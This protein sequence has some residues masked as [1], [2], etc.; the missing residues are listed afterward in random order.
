[1]TYKRAFLCWYP[2]FLI[3]ALGLFLEMAVIRWLAAEV[4]LFSYFKNLPLMAAFL[5]LGIGF[6]LVGRARDYRPTFAL[7]IGLFVP[8]VLVVGRLM[9]PR[10]LAYPGWGDE[11]LWF[12]GDFAYWLALALFLG[13]VITFFLLTMFLFI[14]LGQAT[15][16]EMAQHKPVP[17]Y[18]V[19]LVGSLAGIWA[20]TLLSYWHTPPA[21]WFGLA[22]FG[23]GIYLATKRALSRPAVIIFV[24][25]FIALL[26]FGQGTIWSP[27]HRL[28]FGE[29]YLERESNGEPVK[30]GYTLTVQ[31]VFYQAATDL[32]EDF[33][34][35]LQGDVRGM[36]EAAFSYNL[37]YR[38]GAASP[39]VLVV[40]A[41]MG[42]DVAAALRQDAAHVDA[43]E[44][45]PAILELGHELH[46][47]APYDDARVTVI[48]DDARSFL[49]KSSDSYDIIAFGLLDS[50]TL[51]S[52]LSSVR[53]DS[54]VYT[55]ESFEQVREHLTDNGLVAVTFAVG[56]PWIEERLGQMLVEVF[57]TDRVFVYHGS[58]GTTF[59]TGSIA[60]DRLAEV[61]LSV[62][63]P[64]P[65]AEELPLATDDWP[66]LY[67]RVRKVPTAYW[68]ALLAIG[69]VCVA[70]VARS[71]P[72]ALRPKWHFFLLGAAFLLIEFKIITELALLFGTTWLVN[73]LAVSGVLLMA[74]AANLV[75]LWRKRLNLRIAY[76][77]LFVSLGANYFFPLSLLSGFSPAIR[78]VM[79]LALLSLPLF[80]AGLIFGESL[81]RAKETARPLASN[82]IGSVAGGV[83]FYGSLI[84]G[85]KS[86]ILIA[87][88]IYAGSLL[89]LVMR[90]K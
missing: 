73:V 33:L 47:E 44:I 39:Q 84:W 70:V 51:L 90:K 77:L 5:G 29:L 60:P 24:A 16:K 25:V 56:A 83:L 10:L 88:V 42:N 22:L 50:Q 2:L 61:G 26:L 87:A 31:Q 85:I 37:P 6:A 23:V 38:L 82:L 67:L 3:S 59:V 66:Y 58:I 74:L 18:T 53:L 49:Q 7:R 21:I 9:S 8:L 13:V 52:G 65:A 63:E 45:D 19:N 62:W 17:A 4:R 76:M 35:A 28:D 89:A 32:S 12:T 15:G 14:P 79:G 30:V 69:L 34:S 1:M 81:R 48:T 75:V 11:F 46:P 27:Y 72:G 36:D 68:Q 64:D 43:V 57:G 80:F 54:F 86:L 20:F 40:G 78:A 71:F 41:G 55:I